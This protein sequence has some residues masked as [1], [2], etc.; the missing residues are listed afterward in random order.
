MLLRR[1]PLLP[2]FRQP[3]PA[4]FLERHGPVTVSTCAV[5]HTPGWPPPQRCRHCRPPQTACPPPT[6]RSAS[7]SA[8]SGHPSAPSRAGQE[9]Q[10]SVQ[11]HGP[12][13]LLRQPCRDI[14][15]PQ[16][17]LNYFAPCLLCR[18]T[19]T[20]H[21][22]P[23]CPATTGRPRSHTLPPLQHTHPFLPSLSPTHTSQ[24][25][26]AGGSPASPYSPH[27]HHHHTSATHPNP[28]RRAHMMSAPPR[29]VP[30]MVPPS[31]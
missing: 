24:R 8:C 12:F 6:G 17:R 30:S 13:L 9:P 3:R 1:N 29:D 26:A 22:L 21:A 18:C 20:L 4:T 15:A 31:R 10:R 7:R 2:P 25:P 5:P 11:A 14:W 27:H 19:S 16:L 23:T 28:P